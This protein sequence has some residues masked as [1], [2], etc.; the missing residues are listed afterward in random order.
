MSVQHGAVEAVIENRIHAHCLR[1][2]HKE[3]LRFSCCSHFPPGLCYRIAYC[4]NMNISDASERSP[5]KDFA[6]AKKTVMDAQCCCSKEC[7]NGRIVPLLQQVFNTE[8]T[9]KAQQMF[10]KFGE[11]PPGPQIEWQEAEARYRD[12]I[13]KHEG[14]AAKRELL[15]SPRRA[16]WEE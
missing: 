10:F 14:C 9:M 16:P 12:E 15:V 7:C 13:A 3:S 8:A 6:N 5:C 4:V 11:A 1:R 2:C